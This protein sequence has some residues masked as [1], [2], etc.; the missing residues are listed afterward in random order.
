MPNSFKYILIEADDGHELLLELLF[1]AVDVSIVHLH[2]AHAQQA[3]KLAALLI[4][5]AGAILGQAQRQLTIA[6]WFGSEDLVMERAVHGF[7]VVLHPFQLHRRVHAVFV[8]GQM[9]AV[10]EQVLFGQV[11]APH[12]HVTTRDARPL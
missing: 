5:V 10:Q 12:P 9:P 4:A 1:S 7:D 8:V 11:R 2:R 3:K 6:A